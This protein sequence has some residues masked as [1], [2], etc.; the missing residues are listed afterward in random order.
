MREKVL[1]GTDR[2]HH[3]NQGVVVFYAYGGDG[4]AVFVLEQPASWEKAFCMVEVDAVDIEISSVEFYV[5]F[6]ETRTPVW[7]ECDLGKR[8]DKPFMLFW[9]VFGESG[10]VVGYDT[11]D[12]FYVFVYVVGFTF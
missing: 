7:R 5:M 11:G 10:Q 9:R 3:T 12:D 6:G 4:F 1:V 8:F 2:H